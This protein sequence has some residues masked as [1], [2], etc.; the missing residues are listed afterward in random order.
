M[1]GFLEL[2]DPSQ[3]NGKLLGNVSKAAAITGSHHIWIS[4][5]AIT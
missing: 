4:R 1:G 3:R 2:K 5:N